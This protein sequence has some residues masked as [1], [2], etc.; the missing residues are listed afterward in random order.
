MDP[1]RMDVDQRYIIIDE[2]ARTTT[3]QL[4]L[5]PFRTR[6]YSRGPRSAIEGFLLEAVQN[7]SE[8]TPVESSSL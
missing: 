4:A 5:Q 3:S 1:S 7:V 8:Q 6:E 2:S